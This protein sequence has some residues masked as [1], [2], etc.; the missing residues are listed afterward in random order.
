MP[1]W[2][3]DGNNIAYSGAT[4]G[5]Q[6]S[7]WL[8]E[9]KLR[10]NLR[11]AQAVSGPIVWREDSSR[12]LAFGGRE[13]VC[14]IVPDGYPTW[15]ATL[16]ASRPEDNAGCAWLPN[17]DSIVLLMAGDLWIIEGAEAAKLTTTGDVLG[18]GLQQDGK[19]IVWARASKDLRTALLS[20]YVMPLKERAA[21]RTAA[22]RLVSAIAAGTV[23]NGISVQS[24]RFS[25]N[26]ERMAVL[27]SYADGGRTRTGVFSMRLDGTDARAAAALAKGEDAA[28]P[29][30]S[31]D[32]RQLA[33]VVIGTA[34]GRIV[35]SNADGTGRRQVAKDTSGGW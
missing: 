4:A 3:P 35:V 34:Y 6:C 5:K 15:R 30:F 12:L 13:A 7:V 33:V 26:G 32:G 2:S 11:L 19:A 27:C 29:V 18:F 16:P 28:S 14:L 31:R 8:Y 25:P 20:V 24:V 9:A 21:R 17:T 10:K 22:P 1:V 23:E